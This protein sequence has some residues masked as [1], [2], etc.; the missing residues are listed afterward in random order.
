MAYTTSGESQDLLRRT[1]KNDL[2][3]PGQRRS[4]AAIVRALNSFLE[5]TKRREQ[6][7]VNTENTE[8]YIRTFANGGSWKDDK[9]KELLWD[10]YLDEKGLMVISPE[11]ITIETVSKVL[12]QF[13]QKQAT[14]LEPLT[15]LLGKFV[16][17]KRAIMNPNG[18]VVRGFIEFRTTREGSLEVE[19]IHV[20]RSHT[21]KAHS[22]DGR[23]NPPKETWIGTVLPRRRSYCM[24]SRELQYGT[25]K[26]AVLETAHIDDGRINTLHGHSIE[27]IERWGTGNVLS[28]KVYM[29][30]AEPDFNC[31]SPLIDLV[32]LEDLRKS[33]RYVIDHLRLGGAS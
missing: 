14:E 19:E 24:I 2:A 29:E 30:R 1:I 8:H 20:N 18:L 25:P 6:T 12:E 21:D 4:A 3:G 9:T 28:S 5:R 27:C 10:M 13:Y 17:Y 23:G 33:N 31:D 16:V 7:V 22:K 15:G 32:S 11:E 26:F